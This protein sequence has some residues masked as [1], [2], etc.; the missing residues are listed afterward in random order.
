MPRVPMPEREVTTAPLPGVRLNA[1][2]SARTFGA[3]LGSAVADIAE[4]EIDKADQIAVLEADRRL[5]E[6]ETALLHDPKTGAL[7]RRG[8]DAFAVPEE[9]LGAFDAQVAAIE[10]G[11][12]GDR[13]RL[14]FR[15]SA[16]GR[17][18]DLDRALQR[19]VA[20]E[21]K[22]YDSAQTDAYL[23][24]ELAAG[25]AAAGDADRIALAGER[26]RAAVVDHA[27]RNGLPP[28]WVQQK[29]GET[30][31]K[32][33]GGVIERLLATQQ[34]RAAAAYYDAHKDSI[35]GTERARLE[36]A[37]EVGSTRG[38]SQRQADAILAQYPDRAAA[39]TAAKAIAEPAVRDAV[40]TRLRQAFADREQ[41]RAERER[42]LFRNAATAVERTGDTTQVAP[43]VWAELEPAHRT[44]LETRARQVREGVE[45]VTN[46]QRYYDL[47]GLA[48]ADETRHKFVQVDLMQYRGELSNRHFEELA[49][50]QGS[51]RTGTKAD[52]ALDGYRTKKQ[53]VDDSMRTI[54]LDPTVT[55][56]TSKK[57]AE[58]VNLFRRRVDEEILAL[59]AQ[60]GKKATG[61]DV[62]TIVDNL[63]IKGTVP[64]SGWL[65]D[66]SK[67]LYEL[68]PGEAIDIPADEIPPS[69]R[70]KI[71]EALKRRNVAVTPANIAA[72]FRLKLQRQ[73]P[74][75]R[76]TPAGSGA[77][78]AP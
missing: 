63:L 75:E 24:N 28:E 25:I 46:Y 26:L 74:T 27:A 62:Q 41:A 45:P 36:K 40:E 61:Q 21:I 31:T 1:Q 43:S 11:L 34:D 16:T 65:W 54:G 38:E 52:E 49:R 53:I 5:V 8:R 70:A 78:G 55:D 72:A 57:K 68:K 60:T 7:N 44:A 9:A 14:A 51:L 58:Q 23:S 13:Q 29:T 71:E 39:L 2:T 77:I 20:G 3:S 48:S 10:Q 73:K 15:R 59:Q 17:R 22:A 76:Q 69:E 50:L 6:T 37:L 30:Q 67:R 66:D 56:K 42:T 12:R 32:L 19:H 33:H 4:R 47:M 35:V 18:L 64:G